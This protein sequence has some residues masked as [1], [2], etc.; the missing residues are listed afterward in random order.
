MKAL[1]TEEMIN[2]LFNKIIHKNFKHSNQDVFDLVAVAYHAGRTGV[3]LDSIY[4]GMQE[5]ITNEKNI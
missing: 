2:Y 5:I 3:N 1:S 4:N